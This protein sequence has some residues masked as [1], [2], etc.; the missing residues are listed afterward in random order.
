MKSMVATA[1]RTHARVW[2]AA[3]LA[4]LSALA[5]QTAWSQAHQQCSAANALPI[6]S[7]PANA[8]WN[9]DNATGL[10]DTPVLNGTQSTTRYG[11]QADGAIVIAGELQWNQAT[12]ANSGRATLDI[13][14]DGVRYATLLTSETAGGVDGDVG[15]LRPDTGAMVSVGGAAETTTSQP[16]MG[17][18]TS[19]GR[20]YRPFT[21]RLPTTVTQVAS[22]QYVFRSD[23]GDATGDA[24]IRYRNIQITQ[25]K[26]TLRLRKQIVAGR[27]RGTDQFT[28][29]IVS[30]GSALAGT[31]T[32]GTGTTVGN[33]VATVVP[34]VAGA[35]H[36]LS[37]SATGTA[38]PD[39]YSTTYSCTNAS[40]GTGTVLPAGNGTGFDLTPRAGDDITCTLVN[41]RKPVSLT[42]TKI[43]QGTTGAF[44][45][46]GNN[47]WTIQTLTTTTSDVG[48]TGT[49][50]TLTTPMA[51]T[52][53][54]EA[55]PAGVVMKRV[56][57][58]GMGPGGTL[59]TGTN[60]FT[61]DA[62]ATDA[63][64]QIACTVVNAVQEAD[65]QVVKTA[66]PARVVSGGVVTYTLTVRN[67]GPDAVSN[68]VLTDSPGAGQTCTT[69]STTATCSAT[70]GA[71][72]PS[73]T[74]PVGTLLGSGMTIPSLPMNGQVTITLRCTVT[75]SGL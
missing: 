53:I 22:V 72:C 67:N 28:L 3:A 65:V 42:L 1:D 9:T 59:T 40:S 56:T 35:L 75:A 25:C 37:E 54:T 51:R 73:P 17:S 34:F 32:T 62:A 29:S 8:G 66:L 15:E 6:I 38:D 70:G 7:S 45:F 4:L 39:D 61:L 58:I 43:S 46:T 69:P 21:V 2:Q 48:V 50:Q 30:D 14:V 16:F 33:G 12:N 18:T 64:S 55:L 31:T 26:A 11:V 20:T 47:G 44:T 36:T 10:T 74:V 52:T 57:C 41:T 71:A 63:G 5:S 13:L 60:T 68:V 49:T 24:D 23:Y 27:E 19:T